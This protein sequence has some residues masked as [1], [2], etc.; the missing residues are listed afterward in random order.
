MRQYGGETL[1]GLSHHH[2]YGI[3]GGHEWLT[4]RALGAGVSVF[5]FSARVRGPGRWIGPREHLLLC[6]DGAWRGSGRPV[7]RDL[8]GQLS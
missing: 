2:Q 8:A 4:C 1:H 7:A 5:G 3:K 6:S